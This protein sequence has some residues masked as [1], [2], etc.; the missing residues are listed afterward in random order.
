M[1]G[2]VGS[3]SQRNA[4][5]SSYSYTQGFRTVDR[6]RRSATCHIRLPHRFTKTLSQQ[7]PQAPCSAAAIA[8]RTSHVQ[9]GQCDTPRQNYSLRSCSTACNSLRRRKVPLQL[10]RRGK[11]LSQSPLPKVG[12]RVTPKILMHT[13]S[14]VGAHVWGEV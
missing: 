5:T 7:A 6:R 11:R 13:T 10:R 2:W 4:I 9:R 8:Q 14:T 12:Y 1:D 3:F